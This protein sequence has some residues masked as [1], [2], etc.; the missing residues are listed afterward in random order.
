M[1]RDA[2]GC[3]ERTPTSILAYTRQFR[4]KCFSHAAISPVLCTKL[5]M[6]KTRARHKLPAFLFSGPCV[7]LDT[8]RNCTPLA[9]R[10]VLAPNLQKPV[11]SACQ[12]GY[13]ETFCCDC[14]YGRSRGR[15]VLLHPAGACRS[16]RGVPQR[17]PRVC[18][19]YR[20]ED[21]RRLSPPRQTIGKETPQALLKTASELVVMTAV[22]RP[23]RRTGKTTMARHGANQ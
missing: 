16:R 4:K 19:A 21:C 18:R 6:V 1:L 20:Y 7:A 14:L 10:R 3:S 5:S 22:M 13:R 9:D 15:P 8:L 12:G 11:A 23:V 17:D 2:A